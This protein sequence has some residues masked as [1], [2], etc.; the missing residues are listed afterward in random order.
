M[1]PQHDQPHRAAEARFIGYLERLVPRDSEK[2]P[3]ESEHR[4]TL[5]TLRRGLGREAGTVTEMYQYI[6]PLLPTDARPHEEDAYFLVAA[7]FALHPH[8]WPPNEGGPRNNFGAS[9]RRLRQDEGSTESIEKRFV[10]LLDASGE[11]LAHHLRHAI[12]LMRAHEAPVNYLL[13]LQDIQ[14]WSSEERR[15]Q[16]GWARAYWGSMEPSTQPATSAGET[17]AATTTK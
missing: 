5:A 2:D 11:T 16:R 4:A 8:H 17:G 9:F 12:S 7:L 1:S 3:R 14:H 6:G 15:V 10:A 13:L